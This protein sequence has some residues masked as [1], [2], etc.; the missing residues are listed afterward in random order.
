MPAIPGSVILS[1]ALRALAPALAAADDRNMLPATG[2]DKFRIIIHV[3]PEN[4]L[5]MVEEEQPQH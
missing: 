4:T 2:T 1:L 3:Q 5:G